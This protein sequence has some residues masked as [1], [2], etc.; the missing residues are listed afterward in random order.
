MYLNTYVLIVL[1]IETIVRNMYNKYHIEHW[2]I[3]AYA[4]LGTKH[5]ICV[6]F[7]FTY[8]PYFNIYLKVRSGMT[9]KRLN[10]C[11]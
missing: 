1:F 5:S 4:E 6:I 9:F 7:E 11:Y 10:A 3:F 8:P 2:L